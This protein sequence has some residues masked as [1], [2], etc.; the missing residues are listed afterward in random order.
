MADA[1]RDAEIAGRN[2][3][4]AKKRAGKETGDGLPKLSN[5]G[6]ES[7]TSKKPMTPTRKEFRV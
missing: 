5:T 3:Q 1:V 4:I 6:S 2:E 7:T